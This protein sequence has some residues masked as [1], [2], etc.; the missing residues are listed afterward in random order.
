MEESSVS[1]RINEI[2]ELSFSNNLSEEII[3]KFDDDKVQMKLSFSVTGDEKRN[4]V[5]IV[6]ITE[7]LY[8]FDEINN[9]EEFLKLKTNT[10]FE[11]KDYSDSDIKFVDDEIFID[12]NL[13][14][15]FLDTSIGITR[16]MLA[17]KV[18]SLPV[19]IVLP[20]FN[21]DEIVSEKQEE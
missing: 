21:I 4:K 20:L 8:M 2:K 12:D 17:Y 13:M 5:S 14:Y 19:N 10:D 16:G 18:A 7:F 9:L 15:T 11:I 1:L 3:E 6:I